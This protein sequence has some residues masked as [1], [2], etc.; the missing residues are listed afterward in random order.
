VARQLDDQLGG[1][2]GIAVGSMK[3]E[4]TKKHGERSVEGPEYGLNGSA[5]GPLNS[6]QPLGGGAMAWDLAWTLRGPCHQHELLLHFASQSLTTGS[7]TQIACRYQRLSGW[8]VRLPLLMHSLLFLI[9][10]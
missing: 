3:Q 4:S 9:H 2:G 5:T 10:C 6:E 8:Q 1:L 7:E